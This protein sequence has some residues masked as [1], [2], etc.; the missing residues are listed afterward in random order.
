MV[1]SAYTQAVLPLSV[2]LVNLCA[3]RLFNDATCAGVC[4][5]V[6]LKPAD[7]SMSSLNFVLLSQAPTATHSAEMATIELNSF[8]YSPYSPIEHGRPSPR[9]LRPSP[10]HYSTHGLKSIF[11]GLSGPVSLFMSAV[12]C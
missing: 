11:V 1:G 9:A 10:S 12:V 7:D 3:G 5:G 2:V 4:G 6:A 8:I